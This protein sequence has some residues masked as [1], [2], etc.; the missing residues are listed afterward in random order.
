MFKSELAKDYFA[1]FGITKSFEIDAGALA[2]RYRFLQRQAHPDMHASGDPMEKRI[3]LQYSGYVNQAYSTLRDANRRAF[4]LLELG[5]FA[6]NEVNSFPVDE[7]FLFEQMML[8]DR[9]SGLC[10]SDDALSVIEEV[11]ASLERLQVDA[12]AKFLKFY[13]QDKLEQAAPFANCLQYLFK[14]KEELDRSEL[15]M[16]EEG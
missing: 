12:E 5:G 9:I 11:T 16:L 4:Y 1:L 15:K 10:D 7:E 13:Q 14:M 6:E 8:R 2:E 3:A